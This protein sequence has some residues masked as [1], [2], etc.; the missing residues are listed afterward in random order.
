M[1]FGISFGQFRMGQGGSSASVTQD[2]ILHGLLTN[3]AA[4]NNREFVDWSG[5]L[6]PL[7]QNNSALP[8][9][10]SGLVI[11]KVAVKY[12]FIRPALVSTNFIF[13]YDIGKLT[14]NANPVEVA[15]YENYTDGQGV[16]VQS[17]D[18]TLG[19]SPTDGTNFFIESADLNIPITN[20]DILAM[21]GVRVAGTN[22]G[23]DNEEVMVS[24]LIQKTLTP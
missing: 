4:R 12:L 23:T 16:I 7:E 6:N 2:I 9:L 3:W 20:G 19:G 17:F 24:I 22:E 10:T 11:K 1:S 5:S 13:R 18:G 15:N 21:T 8:I 14:N